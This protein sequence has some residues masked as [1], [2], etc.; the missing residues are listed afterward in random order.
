MET[1]KIFKQEHLN[2]LSIYLLRL[3]EKKDLSIVKRV[4]KVLFGDK[5]IGKIVI[6]D[7][8][9]I[10]LEALVKAFKEILQKP[11]NSR[12][13]PATNPYCKRRLC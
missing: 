9:P 6:K 1:N 7:Q 3:F 8:N 10:I 12:A 13:A 11:I 2:A 5:E 4:F